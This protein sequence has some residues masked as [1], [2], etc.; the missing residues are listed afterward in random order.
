MIEQERPY[1]CH[2]FVCAN[3]RQGERRSCADA[4]GPS[5]LSVLKETLRQRGV[6][7][8]RV[9]QTG[10]LGQCQL[11]PNVMIEPAGIHFSRVTLD[12][13]PAI[14]DRVEELLADDA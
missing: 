7:G 14:A 8:V 6:E 13:V 3:N 5:I 9:S 11:G 10:C 1:R 12:D 4:G 2:V